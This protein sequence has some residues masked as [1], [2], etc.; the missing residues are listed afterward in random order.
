[1]SIMAIFSVTS[2]VSIEPACSQAS[3]AR[4]GGRRIAVSIA[5]LAWFCGIERIRRR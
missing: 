3:A 2:L 4:C 1:M 5:D